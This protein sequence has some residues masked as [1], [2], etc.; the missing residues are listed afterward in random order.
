MA[1]TAF[2]DDL[3]QSAAKRDGSGPDPV[4]V[5]RA[6]NQIRILIPVRYNN[7]RDSG[8]TAELS[9]ANHALQLELVD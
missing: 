7:P 3:V 6:A 5:A 4:E 1:I 2:D 9:V 8:L